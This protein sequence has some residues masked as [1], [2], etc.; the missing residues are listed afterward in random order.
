MHL[1]AV[2]SRQDAAQSAVVPHPIE[3][4]VEERDSL[5]LVGP[6]VDR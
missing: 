3:A 4:L 5:L 1:C 6:E 2:V